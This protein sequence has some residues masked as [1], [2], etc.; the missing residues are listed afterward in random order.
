LICGG[1]CVADG[2]A[3]LNDWWRQRGTAASSVV[4]LSYLLAAGAA[5]LAVA[6]VYNVE[7]QAS[8]YRDLYAADVPLHANG[9]SHLRLGLQQDQVIEQVVVQLLE[10]CKSLLTIP[11]RDSFNEWSGLP[12]PLDLIVVEH[13]PLTMSAAEQRQ[14]VNTER[15]TPGLCVLLTTQTGPAAKTGPAVQYISDHYRQIASASGTSI[16]G[17]YAYSIEVR[18]KRQRR[19]PRAVASSA[20]HR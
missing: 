5:A 9:A 15:T 20:R 18:G 2:W 14:A 16:S 13:G 3:D 10:H 8:S 17:N 11:G 12:T 19:R 7:Q 6:F 4:E 1:I